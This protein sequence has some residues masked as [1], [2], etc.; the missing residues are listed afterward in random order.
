MRVDTIL[1]DDPP[2]LVNGKLADTSAGGCLCSRFQRALE[3]SGNDQGQDSRSELTNTLHS[4]HSV[5]HSTSP[6][7]SSE[8]RSNNGR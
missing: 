6:F 2:H 3:A 8:F 7:G 4:E 1:H 5:H